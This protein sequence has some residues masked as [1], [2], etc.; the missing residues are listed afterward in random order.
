VVTSDDSASVTT[1]VRFRFNFERVFKNIVAGLVC[2]FL[3]IVFS[4]SF[5]GLLLPVTMIRFLPAAIG[6]TLFSTAVGAFISALSSPIL[7][8]VSVVEEVPLVVIAG[9]AGTI[10]SDMAGR[11]TPGATFVTI[12]AATMV[13][14]VA[15]GLLLLLLGYFKLGSLVRFVPFPVVGG[16]MAGMGWLVFQ[17]GVSLVAGTPITLSALGALTAPA[18]LLK[19]AVAVAFVS[20]IVVAQKRSKNGLILPL[21][22]LL[23]LLLFN[24]VIHMGRIGP[25]VLHASGWLVPLPG[26]KGLW[27][28]ISPSDLARVDWSEL[29]IGMIAL[30]GIACMTVMALLMNA[31]GIEFDSG[32]DVDLDRELRSVGMQGLF[33]GLGGGVPTFSAVSLTLL[34]RRLGAA[35]RITGLIVAGLVAAA[36]VLG[37][38]V[39]DIV[40]T[41]LLG[42]LLAWLGGEL[43]V[44]WLIVQARR[45]MLREY[46]IILL[47]FV[48]IVGVGFPFG[49]LV[50]LI[51]AVTL[52]VF[53]YGRVETIRY[54][55]RGSEYQSNIEGSEERRRMLTKHGDAILILRLQGYLFFGTAEHL[56]KRVLEE[57]SSKARARVRFVIID[58]HRVTGLD[59]S[60]ALSFVRFEQAAR[61]DRFMLV[62]TGGSAVVRKALRRG[63]FAAVENDTSLRFDD[64]I[65]QGLAWCESSL[66]DDIA[67]E[68]NSAKEQSLDGFLRQ[69]LQSD[70]DTEDL[71]RYFE[72]VEIEAG[73]T[74]I[75]EGASSEDIYFVEAGRAAVIIEGSG[76]SLHLAQIGAGAIVGEVAFFLGRSRTASVVAENTLIA[77]RFTR[78]R[79]RQLEAERPAT[80]FRLHDGFAAI[81]ANRLASTNRLVRFFAD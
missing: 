74:L 50:G 25:D 30:P 35:N 13:A 46:A 43:I 39:L 4:I 49:I 45:L 60:A 1:T 70:V 79:L 61:R 38:F 76:G 77:W 42:G 47:I 33:A 53:E 75:K 12:V 8:S 7:G 15:T 24:V 28:P 59:S 57:I 80:A 19:G 40:P 55:L 14:T 51:A 63:G 20:S 81:L 62:A 32:R 64:N 58:F 78:A 23:A 9:M 52:F 54:V 31:S 26:G 17:G 56:R 29:L 11:A 71:L 10:A 67:P 48:V 37:Q 68:I 18:V 21:A 5:G 44:E 34:A 36:I 73:D 2:G 72:R 3:G 22:S 16:F 6:M 41:P 27:P 66:L 69:I 65:E